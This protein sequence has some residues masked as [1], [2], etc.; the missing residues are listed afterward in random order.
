MK[1]CPHCGVQDHDEAILC[2]SCMRSFAAPPAPRA[3]GQT[4][5]RPK[6]VLV[7]AL[8]RL[9]VLWA[10]MYAAVQFD[11]PSKLMARFNE[12][13]RG[14][15]Q[16]AAEEAP[17]ATAAVAETPP[18]A[19]AA[20][21]DSPP[22]APAAP[23]EPAPPEP[24]PAPV[25]VETPTRREPPK[26]SPPPAPASSSSPVR[27]TEARPPGRPV[28]AEP[29][30]MTTPAPSAAQ[31]IHVGGDIKAP[32]K[33]RD[34]RPVYPAAAQASRIQGIVIIEAT[35]GADGRVRETRVLRPVS[36]LLDDAAV[37]AVRQWEYEPTL[38]NGSPVP[39]I[40]TVT[41]NFRLQ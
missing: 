28:P 38:L 3:G 23:P 7:T 22:P 30:A 31:P 26:P 39:V 10:L 13:Q 24:A 36:P 8:I 18:A 33:T 20:P 41:V 32:A 35:I 4:T 12:W 37:E 19:P 40:M 15:Q 27:K 17:A 25:V 29:P 16:N 11:L 21:P 5:L 2:K 14:Q 9:A 6:S 34:V 1:R